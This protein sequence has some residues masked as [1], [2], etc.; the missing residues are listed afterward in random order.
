MRGGGQG[1]GERVD[2]RFRWPQEP[3]TRPHIETRSQS[4][5]D[6]LSPDYAKGSTSSGFLRDL[7]R[8]CMIETSSRGS[9]PART[10]MTTRNGEQKGP[11][12]RGAGNVLADLGF[13][14]AA[15]CP[16]PIRYLPCSNLLDRSLRRTV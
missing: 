6:E 13:P 2:R 3:N 15:S 12:T 11:V 14:D 16:S 4:H 1:T 10:T 8:R 5:D 9:L 7:E